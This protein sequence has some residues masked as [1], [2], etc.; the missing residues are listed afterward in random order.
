[1]S[2][3]PSGPAGLA[4]AGGEVAVEAAHEDGHEKPEYLHPLQGSVADSGM[5]VTEGFEIK[6]VTVEGDDDDDNYELIALGLVGFVLLVGLA[7]W[8]M[9]RRDDPD[10]EA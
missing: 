5:L 10:R 3:A 1:M 8:W 6:G 9:V 2:P 7:A 4:G